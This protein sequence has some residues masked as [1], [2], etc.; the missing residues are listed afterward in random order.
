MKEIVETTKF[1]DDAM[2]VN[3]S[4]QKHPI[5]Y[6]LKYLVTGVIFGIA[7]VKAEIIS[8]FRIQEMFRFEAFH[9]Y[10]VIGT[11]VV[12]GMISIQI[13]KRFNIKTLYGE[14][15]VIADKTFNKG[16]VY[17]GLI[18]GLGWA[19]P[20]SG[21]PSLTSE[22]FTFFINGQFV[23]P[24]AITSFVNNG[25]YSTLTLN[26]AQLGYSIEATD[27]IVGVGKFN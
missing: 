26:V 16:Q 7:F 14:K 24:A 10:G 15:I 9:M 13:I 22:N 4:D 8:W 6:N 12:I 27:I 18:F 19:I 21:A 5:W 2:C 23:E 11:G 3:E 1:K 25:S 20:P 17:G